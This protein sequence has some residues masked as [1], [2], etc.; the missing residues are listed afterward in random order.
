M[1]NGLHKIGIGKMAISEL[2]KLAD[3]LK[4]QSLNPICPPARD[5]FLPSQLTCRQ[6]ERDI[7]FLT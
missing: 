3:L 2:M 1:M 6:E 5:P 4:I 7:V